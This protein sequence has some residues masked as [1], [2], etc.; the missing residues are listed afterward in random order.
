MH[1]WFLQAVQALYADVPMCVKTATGCTAPFQSLLGVKQG[2]PLSPNLFGMYVD[3]IERTMLADA[4]AMDLPCMHD[5][6]PVPP[7]L[8]ADDL[9]LLA[10]SAEGL[11]KQLDAL[12]AYSDSWG[13]TVNAGKTKVVA[14]GSCSRCFGQAGCACHSP[15]LHR[16]GP[17]VPSS[18]HAHVQH[19][20]IASAQLRC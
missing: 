2:C 18:A 1:G 15:P 10:T 5:G 7:L 12:Q 14:V 19:H 17:A 3:D 6:R 8:Y 20:G 16:A 13:L 11:Q 9:V 4:A